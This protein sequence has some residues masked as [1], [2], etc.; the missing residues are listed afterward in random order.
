MEKDEALEKLV[1]TRVEHVG[2]RF[3]RIMHCDVVLRREKS[4]IQKN[5]FVEA[6]LEVPKRVMLFASDRAE[7]FE[8]ALDKVI[9]DLEHQLRRYKE[10][11]EESR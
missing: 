3:S 10:E 6:K 8:L 2:E 4:D 5:F 1:R 7:T 11:L 9:R